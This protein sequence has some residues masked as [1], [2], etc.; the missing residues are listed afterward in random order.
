MYFIVC[1]CYNN[2]NNS[3]FESR[4]CIRM[5]QE[6]MLSANQRN[7]DVEQEISIRIAVWCAKTLLSLDLH[8]IFSG[9]IINSESGH[10]NAFK[11]VIYGNLMRKT[12]EN[13]QHRFENG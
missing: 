4:L 9:N 10:L 1:V 3:V 2:N 8:R 7:R 12:F 11:L 6:L 5:Y 13:I